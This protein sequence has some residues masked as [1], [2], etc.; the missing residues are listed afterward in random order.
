MKI[1]NKKKFSGV[2]NLH[3]IDAITYPSVDLGEDWPLLIREKWCGFWEGKGL[4]VTIHLRIFGMTIK[5]KKI[6][7]ALRHIVELWG[8]SI[9]PTA[10]TFTVPVF[11]S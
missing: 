9:Q 4:P 10:V 5:K 7:K 11:K 3:K 2:H 1:K 6:Y 8:C